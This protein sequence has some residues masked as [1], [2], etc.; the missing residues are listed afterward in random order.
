MASERLCSYGDKCKKGNACK[1]RHSMDNGAS[2]IVSP[3]AQSPKPKKACNFGVNCRRRPNCHFGHPDDLS[4]PPPLPDEK[5]SCRYGATCA[6]QPN[7]PFDHSPRAEPFS[8]LIVGEIMTEC[9]QLFCQQ[10][11]KTRQEHQLLINDLKTALVENTNDDEINVKRGL[12]KE[13]KSQLEIFNS[14]IDSLKNA[15]PPTTDNAA[16]RRLGA[17]KR[18]IKRLQSHLPIYARRKDLIETIRSSRVLILKA[19]TGSG[20]STQLVQYLLDAGLADQ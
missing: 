8:S 7:C 18:E 4:I 15:P 13:Y 2:T 20:K 14:E 10:V 6:K 19:D 12:L 17:I 11:P 16:K 9:Q 3:K 1:F 5:E